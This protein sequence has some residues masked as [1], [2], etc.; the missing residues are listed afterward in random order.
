MGPIQQWNFQLRLC[1]FQRVARFGTWRQFPKFCTHPSLILLGR[2]TRMSG[3]LNKSCWTFFSF[4]LVYQYTSPGWIYGGKLHMHPTES[5]SA[6]PRRSHIF[7]GRKR[8]RRLIQGD[9]IEWKC[10][11]HFAANLFR[12]LSTKLDP[13]AV[14]L[15][16]YGW[17]KTSYGWLA[18]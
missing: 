12:K 8:V 11:Y 10:L 4:F 9:F 5:E 13:R 6:P 2:P 1:T 15:S 7:I 18:G 17:L 14:A 16:R 3:V